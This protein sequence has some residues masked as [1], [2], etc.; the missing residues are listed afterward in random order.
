M[1]TFSIV[2]NISCP[3]L[4]RT[5]VPAL[6]LALAVGVSACGEEKK[7]SSTQ[8]VEVTT[9]TTAAPADTSSTTTGAPAATF[10]G[11]TATTTP[12]SDSKAHLLA[13][14][15]NRFENSDRIVFEF[16][17]N[18][19]PGYSLKYNQTGAPTMEGSPVKATGNQQLVI[20]FEAASIV[21]LTGGLK[22]FY[23][24]PRTIDKT[25]TTQVEQLKFVADFEARLTW[26]AG[27]KSAANFKVSTLNNPTRVVIDVAR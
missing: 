7:A 23:K 12:A 18:V 1:I 6:C 3:S 27:T 2:L 25:D 14:R 5:A 22:E 11:S 8:T 19:P 26:V 9:S 10:G 16:D 13:V 4:R 15:L 20:E 21:E 17:G 24:G